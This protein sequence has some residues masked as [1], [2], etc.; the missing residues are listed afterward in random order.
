VIDLSVSAAHW[1]ASDF[2]WKVLLRLDPDLRT[3]ARQR[4]ILFSIVA[5]FVSHCPMSVPFGSSW[6]GESWLSH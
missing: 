5:I 1:R 3:L 4:P 6:H 2:F